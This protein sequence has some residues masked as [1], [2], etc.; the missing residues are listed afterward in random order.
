MFPHGRQHFV[1]TVDDE[2]HIS[3]RD[4][5]RWLDP[6]IIAPQATFSQQD[7]AFIRDFRNVQRFGFGGLIVSGCLYSY[8][9][10]SRR[11]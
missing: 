3:F 1:A 5:H 10:P 6:L 8:L 7:T 11:Q 4:A 2:I 9:R